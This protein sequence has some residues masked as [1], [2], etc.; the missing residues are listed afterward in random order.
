[1][2][3]LGHDKQ[4]TLIAIATASIF[5]LLLLAFVQPASAHPILSGVPSS[6]PL[7]EETTIIVTLEMDGEDAIK[8]ESVQLDVFNSDNAVIATGSFH[9]DGSIIND[10]GFIV[11]VVLTSG[12]ISD[13]WGYETQ[14]G[15][16]YAVTILLNSSDFAESAGNKMMATLYRGEGQSSMQSDMVSFGIGAQFPWLYVIIAIAV[17]AVVIVLGAVYYF[18]RKKK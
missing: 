10:G 9:A 7:D 3:S 4:K 18:G 16:V 13:D 5:F 12:S 6:I 15:I 8:I 14:E 11:S 1:M 17:I 2:R